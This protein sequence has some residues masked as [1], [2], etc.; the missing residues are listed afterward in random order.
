MAVNDKFKAT[1]EDIEYINSII[2]E[3]PEDRV[4][5]YRSLLSAPVK[6]AIKGFQNIGRFGNLFVPEQKP[7][8]RPQTA[9]EAFGPGGRPY[10]E[11]AER[12][13]RELAFEGL[14]E[15]YLPTS[16]EGV[17]GALSGALERTARLGT[18][19][20]ALG[21][22]P[23]ASLGRG[24]LGGTLGE[25]GKQVGLGELGQNLLEI[26]GTVG[27]DLGKLIPNRFL[28]TQGA[29]DQQ[30]LMEFA[31][32]QGLTEQELNLALGERGAV[33]DFLTDISSKGGRT[34]EAFDT[35]RQ[36]LGRVWNNLRGTPA[37]QTPLSGQES[38]R[39]IN[40]LSNRL[41][42]MPA[43]QRNRIMQDYNDFLSTEMTGSDIMDFWQ[44]LNYYVQRG[45]ARLGTLK[46]D[47]QVAMNSISPELG[48]DFRMTN[49]LYGNYANL[50]ERMGPNIAEHL[51]SQGERGILISAIS[52][53][54]YPMLKKV[55]GPIAGRKLA[56]Q[57]ITNSRFKNLSARFVNGLQRG[58]PA[59]VQRVYDQM[60][61]EIGKVSPEAAKEMS[62]IDFENFFET[63]PEEQSASTK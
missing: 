60:I 44:N 7:L 33:R 26:L 18:E 49:R 25:T 4:S 9:F 21:G 59:I 3:E 20:Y 41:S 15:E 36:A 45:E 2:P 47:L 52:T 30:A 8:D 56:Q 19:M 31:R 53:G 39:L 57:M 14:L 5:W 63:L 54:N 22:Q 24:A 35:T 42:K 51:I 1:D 6:G 40:R 62:G 34:A 12:E 13:D 29:A 23:V 46:E 55:I 43:E 16:E 61:I 17:T 37:A 58:S 32:Q 10:R 50:A 38:S 48:A 28:P 11:P 27:P